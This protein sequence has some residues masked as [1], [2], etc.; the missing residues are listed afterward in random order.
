MNEYYLNMAGL[1]LVLQT[2]WEITISDRMRPFL[3]EQS[4]DSPCYIRL[5]T[6]KSLPEMGKTGQWYGMAWY[7]QT[8]LG[9]QIFHCDKTGGTPFGMARLQPDGNVSLWVKEGCE[10]YFSGTAGI[11][12]RIGPEALLLQ[13]GALLLHSSLVRFGGGAIVFAGPS[14]VGKSTQAALWQ[15]HLGAEVLNGD[16]TVL[17][18][19]NEIWTGYGSPYAGTSGIYR[20]ESAPVGAL[21]VL[22]QAKDNTLERITAMQALR[23][24]WPELSVHRWDQGFVEKSMDLFLRFAQQ[25]PVYML[26]CRPDR[27]AVLLLKEELGL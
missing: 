9:R 17:R 18:C 14:G 27:E 16:R 24:C 25:I 21:V 12:N 5:C 26:S 3:C 4:G 2:P 6:C 13:H 22:N 15:Q 19:Q 10:G 7:E 11:F 1:N 23:R 20:N 8:P